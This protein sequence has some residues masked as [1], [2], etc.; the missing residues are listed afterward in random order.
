MWDSEIRWQ[1]GTVPDLGGF[2]A[3]VLSCMQ[4]L[5]KIEQT[6][7]LIPPGPL[8]DR[9]QAGHAEQRSKALTPN[10][11]IPTLYFSNTTAQPRG[12][13]SL[14][15][16]FLFPMSQRAGRHQ[17][18]SCASLLSAMDLGREATSIWV[19]EWTWQCGISL[20]CPLCDVLWR[21]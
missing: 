6:Y 7:S 2:E 21:G 15:L 20:Q 5:P 9:Q 16:T 8:E 11:K 1:R 17:P 18:G 14:V 3:E 12:P 13:S 10:A 19:N 4:P